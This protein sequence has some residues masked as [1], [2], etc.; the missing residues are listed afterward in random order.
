MV[1]LWQDNGGVIVNISATLAHRGQVLQAHSGSAKAAVGK[2]KEGEKKE[3]TCLFDNT[4]IYNHYLT[5]QRKVR[6][7]SL[8]LNKAATRMYIYI[9]RICTASVAEC[10]ACV[11]E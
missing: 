7:L 8:R 1:I 11:A 2:Y 4:T 6:R 9:I 5:A 3:G 10:T